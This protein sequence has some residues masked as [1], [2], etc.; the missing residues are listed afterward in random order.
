V[1]ARPPPAYMGRLL[2]LPSA[3]H[4]VGRHH[5][6]PDHEPV[7]YRCIGSCDTRCRRRNHGLAGA[8]S[9]GGQVNRGC[10]S[11]IAFAGSS[12]PQP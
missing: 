6:G 11:G 5:G 2:R 3:G 12:D 8:G 7:G 10:A 9:D 4:W 1:P